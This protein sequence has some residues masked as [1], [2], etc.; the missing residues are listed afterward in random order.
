MVTSLTNGLQ[1]IEATAMLKYAVKP[2]WISAPSGQL[3]NLPGNCQLEDAAAADCIAFAVDPVMFG[4][5]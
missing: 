5:D 1:V 3:S 4:I 2:R